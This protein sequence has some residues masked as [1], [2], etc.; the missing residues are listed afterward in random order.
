MYLIIGVAVGAHVFSTGGGVVYAMI[1]G[2]GAFLLASMVISVTLV[3]IWNLTSAVIR[4][5]CELTGWRWLD[6]FPNPPWHL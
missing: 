5:V 1:L 4:A 6:K 3:A 2:F